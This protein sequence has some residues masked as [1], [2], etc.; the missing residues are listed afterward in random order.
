MSENEYL[1]K[2]QGLLKSYRMGIAHVDVLKGVDISIKSGEFVV[3]V[4]SSGSGKG[5]FRQT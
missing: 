2:A 4:G 1:I 5:S 3:V